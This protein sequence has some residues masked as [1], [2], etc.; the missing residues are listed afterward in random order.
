MHNISIYMKEVRTIVFFV[1]MWQNRRDSFRNICSLFTKVLYI[2][3]RFVRKGT[4]NNH[5]S[6]HSKSVHEWSKYNC[7][8]CNYAIDSSEEL[9][10]ETYAIWLQG[11]PYNCDLWDK[12]AAHK[13]NLSQQV[14][15]VKSQREVCVCVGEDHQ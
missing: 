4:S 10:S 12:K 9:P 13:I 14:K 5:L 7:V 6:Q 15:S 2:I 1:T 11:V 8:L 3:V